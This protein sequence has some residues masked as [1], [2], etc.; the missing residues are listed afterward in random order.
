MNNHRARARK[1]REAARQSPWWWLPPAGVLILALALAALAH[2]GG[3]DALRRYL[4]YGRAGN[5]S[6]Q[7]L[8][9]YEPSASNRFALLGE[10]LV[11]LSDTNVSLIGANGLEIWSTSVRMSAPA[12]YAANGRAVAYDVG[13]TE[14]H[15]LDASGELLALENGEDE[16]FLSARLNRNGW[17][18][19]VSGERRGKN[20]VQVY[21]ASQKLTFAYYASTRFVL[22]AVA[23]DDNGRLAML[24]LG[25][26]DGAFVSDLL[27][28]RLNEEEREADCLLPDALA[29]EIAQKASSLTV[30]ADTCVLSVRTGGELRARYEYEGDHLREY[31][32]GGD[33]FTALVLNRYASG[34]VGRLVTVDAN[35]EELG[36][37]DVREEILGLS[38]AGHYLAV[39]YADRLVVYHP[40][41]QPYASLTGTDGLQDILMGTDGSVLMLGASSATLFLP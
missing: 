19:V 3:F 8:Y 23:T 20:L 40:S 37:L 22:D 11:V 5:Y 28:Y 31:D 6:A 12:L 7:A 38:A 4:H 9:R 26:E 15:L 32:C 18:T 10:S 21:N 36:S 14:L 27:F 25:Q 16:P 1:L 33:G 17:L 35:G 39:L 2:N 41:L 34:S 24:A 13:G 29:L 30:V